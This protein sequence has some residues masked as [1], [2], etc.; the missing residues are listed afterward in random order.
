MVGEIDEGGEGGTFTHRKKFN[1]K[2][3]VCSE[4]FQSAVFWSHFFSI[5][6]YR[7]TYTS[8][9][10]RAPVNYHTAGHVAERRET[11]SLRWHV[12]VAWRGLSSATFMP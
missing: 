3:F 8:P 11:G 6:F 12:R 4:V 2:S 9:A 1:E 7:H 5:S 10:A